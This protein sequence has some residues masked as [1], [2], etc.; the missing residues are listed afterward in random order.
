[1]RS[2]A[3]HFCVL[4]IVTATPAA[5][6]TQTRQ[7]S[8]LGGAV[9]R[10]EAPP[11]IISV[12]ESQTTAFTY[13]GRLSDAGSPANG[14][15]D[16]EFKLFDN[17]VVGDG[18]QYGTTFTLEDV[19]VTNGVFTV[20]LDFGPEVFSG[21]DRFL[22]IGVRAGAS[23]GAFTT[24][25]PRQQITSTPYAVRS[26]SASTADT[27]DTA[28][29]ATTATTA[30]GVSA[31]AGD[32]VVTAV[33]ASASAISTSHV[34]GDVELLPLATQTATQAAGSARPLIDVKLLGTDNL[35]TSGSG[36]LLSLKASGT[37]SFYTGATPEARDQERFRVDNAGGFAAFGELDMGRIP[38]EGAGTRFMWLPYKGATRG[39][40]VNGTQWDDANIGYFST[41]FGHNARASG[42]Y[43]FAAG[44]DSVA[45]NNN[46]VALGN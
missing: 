6:Y 13:Q 42:D 29:T 27:A 20:Q 36:D 2:L 16:L 25:S 21:A 19:Q 18:V 37:Y 43:G 22:E 34:S 39:G 4:L 24:L 26:I 17:G 28:T 7:A 32:S 40:I 38:A 30:S 10:P 31:S 8:P 41:A 5:A 9:T 14:Q 35:G 44:Q 33:N 23:T 45:A 1:M 12:S 3:R 46:S 15:Y 11:A